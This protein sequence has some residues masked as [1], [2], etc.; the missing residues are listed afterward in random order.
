MTQK[1]FEY[2][3]DLSFV[4]LYKMYKLAQRMS[5]N[6]DAYEYWTEKENL[7]WEE[8]TKRFNS[9]GELFK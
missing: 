9:I 4:D 2:L 5:N 3:K 7:L 8:I 6:Y 1:D